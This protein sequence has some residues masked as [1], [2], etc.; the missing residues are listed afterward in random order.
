LTCLTSYFHRLRA[1]FVPSQF[2]DSAQ[3]F[4][5]QHTR[6]SFMFTVSSCA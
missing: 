4:S 2:L 1:I 3:W 5:D 6:E